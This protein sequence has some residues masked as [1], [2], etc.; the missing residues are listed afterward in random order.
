MAAVEPDLLSAVE[1]SPDAAAAN[2]RAA[3]VA[4]FVDDG[5]V[6]DPVG[7][8]PHV[9]PAQIGAFY[10]TFIAPRDIAFHRDLDIARDSVVIRDLQLEVAMENAVVMHIP[11]FLRYDLRY[12]GGEWRFAVLRAYWELPAMM[13]QYLRHGVRAVPSAL[14]LSRGLLR[15]QGLT[16][17]AGFMTGLRLGV[18]R[19][20]NLMARFLTA[21]GRQ[22]RFTVMQTLSSD[23]AVAFGDGD[24][25]GVG[26]LIGALAGVRW[27]KMIGA[28]RTV[29]VSVETDDGRG[30]LFADLTQRGDSITELR[31]FPA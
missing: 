12:V 26:R 7:S 22:D 5:R 21:A 25:A 23:A 14:G 31:Y 6:E 9:G 3:W 8:R 15:N 30:V 17:A 11:A 28:D 19:N 18:T 4:L 10:D 24:N 27:D 29:V 13:W 1:R 20:K 2:D 16:G